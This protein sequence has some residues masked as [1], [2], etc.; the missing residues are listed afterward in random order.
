MSFIIATLKPDVTS[1]VKMLSTSYVSAFRYPQLCYDLLGA[2]GAV[3]ECVR[4]GRVSVDIV[5]R[6]M[7][8]RTAKNDIKGTQT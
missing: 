6:R 1:T 2:V 7:A 5:D 8:Y 4:G 3:V